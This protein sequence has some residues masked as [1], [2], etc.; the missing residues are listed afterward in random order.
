M[1]RIK[2]TTIYTL[3]RSCMDKVRK[4]I[5]AGKN[6]IIH[7]DL[8]ITFDPLKIVSR[9]VEGQEFQVS[10]SDRRMIEQMLKDEKGRGNKGSL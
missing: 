2:Q 5:K 8:I 10:A 1:T 9:D 6:E 4:G 7:Y 3:S